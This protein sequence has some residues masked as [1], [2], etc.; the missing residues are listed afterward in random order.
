MILKFDILW[1]AALKKKF[2][3]LTID[4]FRGLYKIND[5]QCCLLWHLKNSKYWWFTQFSKIFTELGQV[6]WMYCYF[7]LCTFCNSQ[8]NWSMVYIILFSHIIHKVVLSAYLL[9]ND[10]KRIIPLTNCLPI[11][12]EELG[13][14]TGIF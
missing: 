6:L 5:T 12:T 1:F 8:N 4:K 14:T 9:S 2:A 3:L 11:F 13:T 10:N 7:R